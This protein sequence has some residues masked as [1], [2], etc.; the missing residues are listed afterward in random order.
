MFV[1]MHDTK[2]SINF[3]GVIE[4]LATHHKLHPS[5]SSSGR[6]AA[7]QAVNDICQGM[8]LLSSALLWH[9]VSCDRRHTLGV[10]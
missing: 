9:V 6:G 4:E 2:K 1:G 8:D 3:F 5:S 10:L 7:Q